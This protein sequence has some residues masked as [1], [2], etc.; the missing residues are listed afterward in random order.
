[1]RHDKEAF[2]RESIEAAHMGKLV[3]DYA[4]ILLFSYYARG[5]PWPFHRTKGFIDP[6]TGCFV[7]LCPLT[8]VYLRFCFKAASFFAEGKDD[9]GLAFVKNGAHRISKAIRFVSGE[10][11]PLKQRYERER[12]G[13]NIYYDALKAIE[14]ALIKRDPFAHE[15]KKKA[16][17]AIQQC[18]ISSE[19]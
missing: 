11:S 5:L 1:M 10:N 12:L 13:W 3:G 19:A 16:E 15:L 9:Q 8:V 18:A 2:A 4:R 14:E 6:F 17:C 7:S